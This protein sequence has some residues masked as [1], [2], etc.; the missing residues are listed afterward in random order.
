[1]S[2]YE[3]LANDLT[4]WLVTASD[5]ETILADIEHVL[6][7]G[8]ISNEE[9]IDLGDLLLVAKLAEQGWSRADQYLAKATVAQA[10]RRIHAV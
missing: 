7:K 6:A 5:I 4:R 1:M 3:R 10:R 2:E 9:F 8:D